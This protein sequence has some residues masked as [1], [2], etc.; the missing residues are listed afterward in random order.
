[1]LVG[2]GEQNCEEKNIVRS[3]KKHNCEDEQE[4]RKLQSPEMLEMKML[5]E[6]LQHC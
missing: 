1:M 3:L 5:L 4:D 6:T 2:Y